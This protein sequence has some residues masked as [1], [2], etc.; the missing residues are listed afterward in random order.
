MNK[1]KNNEQYNISRLLNQRQNHTISVT[2]EVKTA[3][4]LRYWQNWQV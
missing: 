4:A 3:I 2:A 1:E